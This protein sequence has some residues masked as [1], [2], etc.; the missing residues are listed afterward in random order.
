MVSTS[1]Q[2]G[3][4]EC[5]IGIIRACV[6]GW[7]HGSDGWLSKSRYH[8]W[9]KET[10]SKPR[11][12]QLQHQESSGFQALGQAAAETETVIPTY[13]TRS[14]LWVA[15]VLCAIVVLFVV[16]FLFVLILV[17]LLPQENIGWDAASKEI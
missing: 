3:L 15:L 13:V 10:L 7:N 14:S 2:M 6:F 5:V 16:F 1:F 9:A 17:L 11:L 8:V 4:L 12:H